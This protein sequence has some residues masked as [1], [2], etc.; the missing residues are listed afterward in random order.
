MPFNRTIVTIALSLI[1]FTEHAQTKL[2]GEDAVQRALS[3]N[4]QL[5][6][7]Q[8]RSQQNAQLQ[9]AAVDIPNPEVTLESPSGQF[10]TVGVLQSFSFPGVYIKQKNLSRQTTDL[11]NTA[12]IIATNDVRQQV[13]RAYLEVQ[14]YQILVNQM[15]QLDSAF[16]AIEGSAL[17]QFEVGDIDATTRTYAEIQRGEAGRR[18]SDVRAELN[19]AMATLQVLTGISDN[20]EADDLMEY[21]PVTSLLNNTQGATLTNQSLFIRYAEQNQQIAKTSLSV[22]KQKALPG[23]AIGYLN[24]GSRD[25]PANLRLRAGITLPL[26]W[27]QYNGKINAAK[28]EIKIA[29]EQRNQQ[30]QQISLLLNARVSDY[31]KYK[32]SLNYFEEKGL[33]LSQTLIDNSRR[34]FDAGSIDYI[35]HL[36]NL[37]EAQSQQRNYYETLYNLDLAVIEIN[38][39]TA[40]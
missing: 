27:W 24:Q 10:M 6:V 8:L 4:P 29:E 26:W 9:K 30:A 7:A 17:R 40:Q 31:F 39:I 21:T 32:F 34:M 12:E 35:S 38:Y 25:T 28:T 5:K 37:N 3:L 11:S 20:I 23:L 2:S 36:R 18:L 16:A 22:Q 14:F 19:A 33:S 13:L 15:Q 1:A